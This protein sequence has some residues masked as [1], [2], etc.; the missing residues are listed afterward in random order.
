MKMTAKGNAIVE[1]HHRKVLEMSNNFI[2]HIGEEKI[3]TFV[4]ILEEIISYKE[5]IR[6]VE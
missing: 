4:T 5:R 1:D 6:N 2:E 3:A